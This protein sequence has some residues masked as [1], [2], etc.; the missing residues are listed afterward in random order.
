M[1]NAILMGGSSCAVLSHCGSDSVQV[2]YCTNISSLDG[3]IDVDL[4]D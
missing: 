3:E 2:M 1:R 4:K